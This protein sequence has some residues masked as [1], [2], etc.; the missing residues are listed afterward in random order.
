MPLILVVEQPDEVLETKMSGGRTIY[1]R[2]GFISTV[3]FITAAEEELKAPVMRA[4][5][6]NLRKVVYQN[7]RRRIGN[8]GAGIREKRISQRQYLQAENM[9]TAQEIIWQVDYKEDVSRLF[10]DIL[11]T[12]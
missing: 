11:P 12:E 5:Q 4:F 3:S 7:Q 2:R 9:I 6:A 1:T 10:E 8:Y